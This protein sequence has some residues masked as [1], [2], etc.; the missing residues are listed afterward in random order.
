MKFPADP[1]KLPQDKQRL[2]ERAKRLEII[3]ICFMVSIVIVIGIVAGSSQTMKAMWVE[4]VLSIVPP[5]AF[6]IGRRFSDK[7]PDNH[8]PYGYRRTVSIAFLTAATT[9]L[10]LGLYILIDSTAKLVMAQAPTIGTVSLFGK[11]IWLGWLMIAALVYGAI[12][13]LVLGRMKL[14]L[15]RELHDKALQTDAKINKGDW[16]AGLAGVGGILGI[17]YGFWWADGIAA[18][19]ISVEIVRDGFGDLKNSVS[20]LMNKTP[21]DIDGEQRDQIPVKIEHE[22]TQLHWVQKAHVRLREDGDVLSGEAFVVPHDEHNLLA[23]L[24]DAK[25]LANSLD[26]RLHDVNVIPA[27][28]LEP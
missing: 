3:T 10:S 8:F 7:P 28:S 24:K 11:R 18:L 19:I 14:S 9:L 16:L 26:W 12:P 21:T 20:Q 17:A 4:D 25:D 1:F 6:L 13:P 22:L 5:T 15:A 2:S 27:R 23:H